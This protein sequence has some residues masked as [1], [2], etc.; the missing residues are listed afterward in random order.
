MGEP[1]IYVWNYLG[2]DVAWGHASLALSTGTYISWW[3]QGTGLQAMPLLPQVY[4]VDAVP[5]QTFADDMRLEENKAPDWQ[6]RVGGLDESAIENWWRSFKTTHQWS[7]LSQN[8][9]TT[10]K[11][12]LYAGGA[13]RILTPREDDHFRG[14]SVWTPSDVFALA[15]VL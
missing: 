10:V 1:S 14:N 12:A 4:T 3:P 8:C 5:N 9:S 6:V 15:E 7:T 13:L 2:K 11:D